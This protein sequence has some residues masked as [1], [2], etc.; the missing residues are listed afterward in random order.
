MLELGQFD[1]QLAFVRTRAQR[2]DVENEAGASDHAALAVLF[3]I[4]LLHRTQDVVDEDQV[5]VV[6]LLDLAQFVDFARTEQETRIRRVG[7]REQAGDDAGAGR[8]REFGE[9][10]EARGR[11]GIPRPYCLDEHGA[12]ALRCTIVQSA[13]PS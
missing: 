5:G 10:V 3:E 11:I 1:L 2:E 13:Q 9:L 8:R 4:A 6:D 12:L 7:P